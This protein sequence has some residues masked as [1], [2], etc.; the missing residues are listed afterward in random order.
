MKR[1]A[2]Q[3]KMRVKEGYAKIAVQETSC[4]CASS[5]C[6]GAKQAK[7]ISKTIGYSDSDIRSVPDGANLGLGCGNPVAIASLKEETLSLIWEAVPDLM[8]SLLHQGLE[9]PVRLSVLI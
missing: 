2:Q 9:K 5:H 7:D 6:G 8:R 4:C 3:I 1:D